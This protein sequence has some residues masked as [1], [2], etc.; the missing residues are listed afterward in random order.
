MFFEEF[1]SFSEIYTVLELKFEPKALRAK[2]RPFHALSLR[3]SGDADFVFDN[4][5]RLHAGAGDII[6]VPKDIGYL[7]DSHTE[8]RVICVHFDIP[9]SSPE[10]AVFTPDDP[11]VYFSLFRKLQNVWSAREPGY[12]FSTAATM[13]NI[14]KNTSRQNARLKEQAHGTSHSILIQAKKMIEVNYTSTELTVHDIA[15]ECNVSEVYLRKIFDK[16]LSTSPKQYIDKL[17]LEYATELLAT[18]YYTVS[19]VAE[20][21]GIPNTKHF[22]TYY[23]A[24][25][26]ISPSKVIK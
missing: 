6:F 10:P 17:R 12:M 9:V 1:V 19:D 23:K 11:E 24:K 20:K 15:N 14:L 2:A 4:G 21:C 3:L 25:T 8:E 5:L 18:G 22:S 7:I 16:Y 26:G 13:N